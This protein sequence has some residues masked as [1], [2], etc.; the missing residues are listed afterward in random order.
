MASRKVL[1]SLLAIPLLV[2]GGAAFSGES[3]DGSDNVITGLEVQKGSTSTQVLLRAKKTPTF[4]VFKLKNPDRLVVD[5]IHTDLTEAAAK[6]IKV[7]DSRVG[8]IATAQFKQAG[9]VVSRVIFGLRKGVRFEARAQGQSV[10]VI[11]TDEDAPKRP[12]QVAKAEEAPMASD[13][14]PNDLAEPAEIKAEPAAPAK[15]KDFEIVTSKGDKDNPNPVR[16]RR[17][18]TNQL[19][20]VT[21]VASGEIETYEVLEV[22]NP[23]RLVVDMYGAKMR[24]KKY[25]RKLSG[26]HADKM[27][28][29]DY[30]GKVRLV[31][32][33]KDGQRQ[34]YKIAHTRNGLHVHFVKT[35]AAVAKVAKPTPA[36]VVAAV[37]A[38][39]VET[40]VKAI[41]PAKVADAL[42]VAKA[43]EAELRDLTFR[44]EKN[45]SMVILDLQG[46]SQPRVV[47]SDGRSTV[48]EIDNCRMPAM[49]ERTLDTS[50]F[51][52]AV[53]SLSAYRVQGHDRVKIVAVTQEHVSNRL[54]RRNGKLLWVFAGDRKQ[55]RRPKTKASSI[56]AQAAS[57]QYNYAPDQVAGYSVRQPELAAKKRGKKGRRRYTGRRISLDFKDADI[58]NILRL[59]SEVAKLNIITSDKVKGSITVTMRNVPWD[60]ALD[61]ILK[62]K[63]LGKVRHGNIVRVA[64]L[65]ELE[66]E[67]KALL[68]K[69]VTRIK[70]EPLRVRLVPVNYAIAGDLA[71]QLKE[72]LSERGSVAIDQRTNVLI[73]KD[74]LE[75]LVKAEGLVRSLDTETPQ[76]LIEARIVE[77]NT[78][79]LKEVGIQ[80]GGSMNNSA[81][82][83]NATGLPF[84]DSA[85][86]KGGA[87]SNIT[88]TDISGTGNPGNFAINLP[89]AVGAGS[90]GALGFI[91][92]SAGGSSVLNLRLSALENK[93]SLKIVSS[94][95]ITTLDNSMAKIGQGVSIPISVTSAAGVNTIFVEAKLELQVTPHITQEGSVLLEIKVTKNEPDFSRTGAKGDPTILKKEAQ[96]QVLVR[97]G[98]TTVIGGIYTRNTSTTFNGIPILSQIPVLGWFFR[99]TQESDDRTELLIFITP[100]IVN[101]L[102]STVSQK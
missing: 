85:I 50:E 42:P 15:S 74:V 17:I 92:G 73:I 89:S 2:M 51:G 62:T 80:W 66:S 22:Y 82:T 87:D 91:F 5:L 26:I 55:V 81:A 49:L 90:G 57:Q 33:M 93:G 12:I 88:N 72:I 77:A 95:K 48:L 24:N 65:G 18:L 11:I 43:K 6:P 60:Q 86:I 70:L 78:Q 37:E 47:H 10:L 76:V 40:K 69:Q 75:N 21:I 16:I 83:N 102:Q 94:P 20:A 67:R 13:D 32:D 25:E 63:G 46:Q 8:R 52:G 7:N 64:T 100:R 14:E 29:V 98:D 53:R 45:E 44:Q 23:F 58:H 30:G 84:P 59:I 27:R 3:T 1:I 54:E 41:A 96:T 68:E 35:P 19:D 28:V 61:I 97:D 71:T 36:K 101:R 4:T 38:K 31:L 79:Y 9:S 39:P 34:P 56:H 99:H